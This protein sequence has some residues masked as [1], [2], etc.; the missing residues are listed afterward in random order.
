[1]KIFASWSGELSHKVAC[2]FRDSLPI[3]LQTV[4]VWVSSE[5]IDK[6]T[7]WA[8]E[9]AS[10]LDQSQFGIICVVPGNLR[11]PWLNFEAGALS[12]SFGTSRVSPFLLGVGRPEVT[13]PLAQFQSTLA[14]KEDVR[15]LVHS[16]NNASDEAQLPEDRVNRSFD[17]WWPGFRDELSKLDIDAGREPAEAAKDASAPV[18][19]STHPPHEQIAIL[20]LLGAPGN[21]Y[22]SAE[23]IDYE[24][25]R[26]LTRTQYH[27]DQLMNLQLVHAAY[28]VLSPIT[29]S[30]TQL[31]RA[32]LVEN[33]LI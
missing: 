21:E 27:L 6:G 13:G 1:M 2:I 12:K 16:I 29:Y 20:K 30:L 8:S 14:E 17:F 22:M 7:H 18:R 24:M 9:I 5:D 23:M 19:S 25:S 26:N 4:D 31:G 10:Q 33:G 3:V 15:K 32:Y 28:N 11:E